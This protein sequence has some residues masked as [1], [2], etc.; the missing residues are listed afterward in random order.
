M[1]TT[2]RPPTLRQLVAWCNRDQLALLDALVAGVEPAGLAEHLAAETHGLP[3][4]L[5]E[6][7]VS[8]AW[9]KL[10]GW[11]CVTPDGITAAGRQLL[12]TVTAA[13]TGPAR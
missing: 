12:D 9:S 6:W 11:D 8:A 13:Q 1:S 4:P 2:T 7:D 3:D 10:L 5:D